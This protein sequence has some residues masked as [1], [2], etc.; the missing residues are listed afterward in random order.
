[1]VVYFFAR[2]AV[3]III[4]FFARQRLSPSSSSSHPVARRAVTIVIALSSLSSSSSSFALLQ[5]SLSQSPVDVIRHRPRCCISSHRR[6]RRRRPARCRLCHRRHHR[7]SVFII[8]VGTCYHRQVH[9]PLRIF[10]RRRLRHPSPSSS[11]SLPVDV[12]RH[13]PHRR[14]PSP[15]A[16]SP[17]S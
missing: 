16:L 3:A 11:T 13:C 15:V 6:H 2:R 8:I 10:H 5:S 12:R 4:D 7:H 1:M 17:S 14:I 9:C